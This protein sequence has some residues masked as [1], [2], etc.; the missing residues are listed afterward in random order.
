MKEITQM[1]LFQDSC[2][3]LTP[4]DLYFNFWLFFFD[5][6]VVYCL[7]Y[8]FVVPTTRIFSW[9][10]HFLF[11][12]EAVNLCLFLTTPNFVATSLFDNPFSRSFKALH[13]SAKAL[14]VS[15]CFMGAIFLKKTSDE[16]LKI[17]WCI[18]LPKNWIKRSN[19]RTFE[20]WPKC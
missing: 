7:T 11:S 9:G 19:F 1:A 17:F 6:P 12:N 20:F 3:F 14:I 5:K 8:V 10:V 16:K 13:F 18:F 15:F 4:E 2:L